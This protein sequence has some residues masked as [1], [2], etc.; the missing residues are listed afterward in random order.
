M[1]Q[2][3]VNGVRVVVF[4]ATLDSISG[5]Y[6][7]VYTIDIKQQVIN[8]SVFISFINY[9]IFFY[10]PEY[11][12]MAFI[13]HMGTSSLVGHYVCHIIKDGRWVIFNDEKVAVSEHPPKDLAYL[14]L[15]KRV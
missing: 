4:N 2:L 15:Y 6:H 13:S 1:Y 11:K 8:R 12:L 7:D 10:F 14:Y 5:K 3:Y 9:W